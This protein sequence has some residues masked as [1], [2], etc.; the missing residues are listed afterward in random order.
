LWRLVNTY[1]H[2]VDD[3]ELMP[4][5]RPN[6]PF[7]V[8]LLA[9]LHIL[10]MILYFIIGVALIAV[11]ALLPRF[12]LRLPRFVGGIVGLI[13]GVLVIIAL[14]YLLLAYGL[15]TGRAWA[16]TIS[17]VI[18]GLAI[19]FSLI[20]LVVRGG[21]G[22]LITLVLNGVVVY[23]LMRPNVKAFFGKAPTPPSATMLTPSQLNPQSISASGAPKFCVNCGAP[24]TT[25]VRFCAHCGAKLV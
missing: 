16:W 12:L 9:V 19:V 6:R 22:G 17:L 24:V 14:L 11:G 7:G 3:Q 20:A 4:L 25:D 18:A 5:Q 8:T 15:W 10:Q 23:Y 2:G 21:V 1:V 13:G